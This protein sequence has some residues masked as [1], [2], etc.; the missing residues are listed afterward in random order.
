MPFWTCPDPFVDALKRAG[1]NLVRLPKADIKPLQLL[2][3]NGDDLERL[4]AVTKLL[5]AGENIAVPTVS[6]DT[7]AGN[8]TGTRTGE[9]KIGLG[10]SLLGTVLGAMG[11]SNLGL[12]TQYKNAKS[13][14]FEFNDVL[15]DKVE[16]V[17]LDQYLG[18]AD[19][20]PASVYVGKLLEADKLYVTTAIIKSTKFT[21]DAKDSSGVGVQLDVPAVQ[22]LVSGNV[23]V[24]TESAT[25][26]KLTYEGKVPLVFGFQ[27]V[28]LYYDNGAYTA[29]KPASSLAMKGIGGSEAQ[30]DGADR[31]IS[32]NT[33]VKVTDL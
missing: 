8:I 31:L 14:S 10:L 20:N 9:M 2:Y 19:I 15:E 7:R 27:A 17:D 16:V 6:L 5:T 18:D 30:D 13:A 26:T 28:Q 32:E 1:Y 23:K 25:S 29:I 4:G 11:G 33:F 24:G 12:E 3:R 22:G 21:F